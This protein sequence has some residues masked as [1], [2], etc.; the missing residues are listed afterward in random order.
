MHGKPR[1]MGERRNEDRRNGNPNE[2]CAPLNA[3][4]YEYK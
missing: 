1:R 3:A 2:C 4:G